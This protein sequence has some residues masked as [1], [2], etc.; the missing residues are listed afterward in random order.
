[1]AWTALADQRKRVAAIVT[2]YRPN[3]HADVIV[4]RL[5][6]GYEYAGERREPAVRVVSMYT[7]QVPPNDMSRD[8]AARHQVE[9][10]PTVRE[11]IT[12]G[13]DKLAVDG[14]VL[15]G[16]HGNYPENEKGQKLYPRY[17]LY[18]QI[19]EVFRRSGRCVPVYCD[20]HLATDWAKAKQ[21]YDE[22][23]GLRFPLMAGSSL[24]VTW[25]RPPIE[26]RSRA[27]VKYAVTAFYGGKE[28]YGFHAL[29]ALQCM[30][31]RRR[32]GETGIAAVAC[33]EGPQVWQWTD[34]NPWAGR[35]LEA[36]LAR[37]ETKKAG[38]PR[39][40]VKAPILFRIAYLSGLL[41][42][43]YLLN[44]HCQDCTFAAE[45]TGE[46]E[47]VTTEIWLQPGPPFSHFSALVH[48]IEQ[49]IV[50]GREPYPPERT[51]LTTGALAALMESSGNQVETP[52]LAVSYRAPRPYLFAREPVPPLGK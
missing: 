37:S 21:M 42:A 40:H 1:M 26:L 47:P 20:K 8:M 22:S 36:A 16:E 32:N 5:L 9:I 46:R 39:D 24:P 18:Q 43:A 30:V 28:A 7:D 29:E 6:E 48:Y 14:V 49:M 15:V 17:P 13:G 11:T 19:V 50:T 25:R 2:E 44:G 41:A 12:L 52:H 35:L 23:R 10:Y 4:G 38:S 51:L 33:L 31:E 27:A 3:S 34:E 45:V